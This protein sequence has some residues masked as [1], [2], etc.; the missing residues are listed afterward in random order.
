MKT[1]P[2]NENKISD[3]IDKLSFYESEGI[4]PVVHEWAEFQKQASMIERRKT[5]DDN[6]I[7]YSLINLF[8]RVDVKR[9]TD[10]E[11]MVYA[12][13]ADQYGVLT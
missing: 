9:L 8:C 1:T 4:P 11:A 5:L 10:E 12:E 2:F 7:L 13:I 6:D 3:I